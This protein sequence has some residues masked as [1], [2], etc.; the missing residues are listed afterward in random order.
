MEI[1][2][3]ICYSVHDLE[4]AINVN[5]ISK[6]RFFAALPEFYDGDSDWKEL[7]ARIDAIL[8]NELAL[9]ANVV[10]YEPVENTLEYLGRLSNES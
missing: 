8:E 1:A 2:D 4:D 3:D 6:E 7:C 5:L 10:D 9:K